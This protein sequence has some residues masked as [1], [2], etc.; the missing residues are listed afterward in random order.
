LQALQA[1]YAPFPGHNDKIYLN[2]KLYKR[3]KALNLAVLKE[4][5]N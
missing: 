2:S 1:E 4:D 3:F 5:K